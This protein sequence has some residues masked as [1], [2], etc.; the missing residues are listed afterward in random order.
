MPLLFYTVISI[1]VTAIS[2]Y[3]LIKVLKSK[4]LSAS[5]NGWGSKLGIVLAMAGNA[6]GLGNFLRFPVQAINNGGGAFIVPYLVCFLL[7]GVPLLFVEWSMG[8]FA[9]I[10]YPGRPN[11]DHNVPFMMQRFSSMKWVK[12]FGGLGLFINVA[13]AGYY[14]Y[15]ESWTLGYLYHSIVG[16]FNSMDQEGISQY[17]VDYTTSYSGKGGFAYEAILFYILCLICNVYFLSKGVKGGIEKVAKIGM[18]LLILFG[19]ILAAEALLLKPGEKGAINAGTEGIKFLFTPD[20]SSI[21]KPSV[22]IA[23]AGQIFFTLAVG[24]ASIQTYA[25]YLRENDDTA[26]G[27]MTAG[28][29]NEFVEIVL[30][31]AIIIPLAIGYLGIDKMRDIVNSLG[32]YGL[33]FRTLPYLFQAWGPILAI[34]AGICW[35]GLLFIAGI[36]SSLAMSTPVV[37]FLQDEFKINQKRGAIIC[38]IIIFL[39]GLPTILF[40]NEGVF[41]EFDNWAGTYALVIFAFVELILFAWVFGMKKGWE[42]ITRGADIHVPTIFKYII[43]Y[44]TPVF[45]GW[46]LISN[47]P[48]MVDRIIHP[49]NGYRTFAQIFMLILLLFI[50][51]A[52]HQAAKRRDQNSNMLSGN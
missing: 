49:A 19:I 46:I 42:E 10:G 2:L 3:F 7:I 27:A 35:F 28:W 51:W 1:I 15:I 30:G 50:F 24:M 31:S 34:I 8:R 6:V 44:I 43:Q 20:Y 33:G 29:M 14:C 48:G 17:F 21:W 16:T 4:A 39:L 18:P 38:G 12:Y 13:V 32:G 23:A 36:T 25:S 52:I 9:G 26:L 41:D 37:G 11:G 5:T 45:L 40:Y 47:I 22:W